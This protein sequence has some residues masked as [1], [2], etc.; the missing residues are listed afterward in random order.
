MCVCVCDERSDNGCERATRNNPKHICFFLF[1]YSILHEI[2]TVART[3]FELDEFIP[4]DEIL[5]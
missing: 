2:K 4:Y 3:Q 1:L 5:V